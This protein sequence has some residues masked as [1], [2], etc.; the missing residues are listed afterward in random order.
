MDREWG[1]GG[2]L[3]AVS[4]P[5][6]GQIPSVSQ[7]FLWLGEAASERKKEAAAWGQEYLKTHPAGRSLAT[8]IVLVK[9]GHEPS[10][11]T[12]WFFTWDPYK[13]TVSEASNALASPYGGGACTGQ[14]EGGGTDLA[15][16]L[17]HVGDPPGSQQ[18][19][20]CYPAMITCSCFRTTS[21]MRR[22]YRAA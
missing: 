14:V 3:Q 21:P 2:W 18:C 11:F 15:K 20:S 12:G 16:G 7:I 22:W 5:T 17:Q 6:P 4:P 10:T 9:Q 19:P 1:G 13:W 8:P